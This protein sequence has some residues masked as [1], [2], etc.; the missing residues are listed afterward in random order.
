MNLEQ[1]VLT[2]ST[3]TLRPLSMAD[4]V[5]VVGGTS[6]L[7]LQQWRW[8]PGSPLQRTD[9]PDALEIGA[10]W[11]SASAQRTRCNTEAKYL[12]LSHAFD[13]HRVA[14]KTDERNSRSRQ[15]IA[16]VTRPGTAS[17]SSGST[18]RRRCARQRPPPNGIAPRPMTATSS[19]LA[20][21]RSSS[22]RST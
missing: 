9:R 12:M 19:R 8:P 21:W 17:P 22:R 2:G 20:P 14:L 6:Y 13:V 3:V 10:T 1:P 15:A 5:R 4:A 11:L 18:T 16:G 7:D